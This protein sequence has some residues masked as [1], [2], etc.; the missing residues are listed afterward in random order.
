[1]AQP[2]QYVLR[3]PFFISSQLM[4]AVN[5]ADAT[6]HMQADTI[7]RD[8]GHDPRVV[9]QYIIEGPTVFH[10]GRD[11]TTPYLGPTA[12]AG[13]LPTAMGTLLGYL[14]HVADVDHRDGD[15]SSLP[16]AVYQWAKRNRDEITAAADL[17]EN[18]PQQ[19]MPATAVWAAITHDPDQ[20]PY[21]RW[22]AGQATAHADR[23]AT[24]HPHPGAATRQ[25]VRDEAWHETALAWY[26]MLTG[27]PEPEPAMWP[28]CAVADRDAI[29]AWLRGPAPQPYVGTMAEYL[30]LGHG[31]PD[32][33]T[34]PD[35]I[36]HAQL[37]GLF[38]VAQHTIRLHNVVD[39]HTGAIS[40][41]LTVHTPSGANHAAGPVHPH[42]L[43]GRREGTVAAIS[44]L[45]KCAAY[46]DSALAVRVT[47]VGGPAPGRARPFPPVDVTQA[48]G[49]STATIPI[50]AAARPRHHR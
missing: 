18:G 17:V 42:Q 28:V 27:Q 35:L 22:S 26:R 13:Q 32:W 33:L 29:A 14:S 25:E 24:L 4:P 15:E 48:E 44:A 6:I 41:L 47:A 49:P 16:D 46:V 3:D 21:G 36:E 20:T 37:A 34:M 12:V 39:A 11:L 31:P 50:P 45:E 40:H 10:A 5:V 38:G 9:W 43:T 8:D 19:P 1:M 2:V 23:L 7:D 30:D